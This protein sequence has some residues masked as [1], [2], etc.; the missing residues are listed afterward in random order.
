MLVTSKRPNGFVVPFLR[1]VAVLG[2]VAM[3]SVTLIGCLGA[4]ALVPH[5]A[6]SRPFLT[7]SSSDRVDMSY[8]LT[9]PAAVSVALETPDGQHLVLRSDEPRAA[10][11]TYVFGFD[12]TYASPSSLDERLVLSDGVYRLILEARDQAGQRQ[13]INSQITI[14]DAD[15]SP[16]RLEDVT[17]HPSTISPNYDGFKDVAVMSYRLTKRARVSAFA[18]NAAGE[19]VYRGVQELLEPGEYRELWD[20]TF[21]DTP[22]PDGVYTFSLQ[23][24]DLAGN[25]VVARTPLTLAGGGRPD[26]R[27][28][29]LSF[30]PTRVIVGQELRV[31][32]TVKNLGAVPLRTQGPSSGH[33]F[34][35]FESFSSIAAGQHIDRVGLWRVGVD[36]AGSPSATGS[37]YPYRWGLGRDLYPGEEATVAGRI[38]VDHGP[39]LDRLVGPPNNRFY[40]YAGLIHEGIAFHDDK[41]GGTWIEVVY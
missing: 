32:A 37:K 24:T 34:S 30:S 25:V 17:V 28:T 21:K 3:L 29:R 20:G 6:L 2:V 22:L 23:A 13:T 9:R 38:R 1:Q 19:R 31:E 15:T 33:L 11:G 18:T 35:S 36:W 12:G 10:P 8:T 39:N 14:R 40:F 16:P 27:I 41:V 5:A 7:P 4:E 26:A